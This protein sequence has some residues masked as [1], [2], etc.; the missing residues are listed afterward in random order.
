ATTDHYKGRIV[1]WTSGVLNG[2]SS[3][4]TAYVGT[5]GVLTYTAVTEAPS[6]TDSFVIT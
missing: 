4:I 3:D 5:N 1:T 2:Q 6:A